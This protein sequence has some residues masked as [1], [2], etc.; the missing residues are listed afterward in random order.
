MSK[1]PYVHLSGHSNVPLYEYTLMYIFIL[2]LLDIWI[3]PIVRYYKQ[4]GINIFIHFSWL[5]FWSVS[6]YAHYMGL[7]SL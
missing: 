5:T 7:E 1:T 4:C 3:V 2:M 6:V